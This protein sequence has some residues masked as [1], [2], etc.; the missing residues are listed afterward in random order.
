[1]SLSKSQHELQD[2]FINAIKQAKENNGLG[3]YQD[4]TPDTKGKFQ[5]RNALVKTLITIAKD[6]ST[7]TKIEVLQRMSE[8]SL[9]SYKTYWVIAALEGGVA[10]YMKLYRDFDKLNI[11]CHQ[12]CGLH[13]PELLCQN[14]NEFLREI[15]TGGEPT[16]AKDSKENT[17]V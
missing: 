16:W 1:M 2:D 15:F 6:M 17:T 8:E 11:R 7:D 12:M 4:I 3:R 10:S 13:I 5:R 14:D 9:S